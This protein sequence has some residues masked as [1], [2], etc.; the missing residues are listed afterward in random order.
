VTVVNYRLYQPADFASLYAIEEVC[1]QPPLRFG[2]RYMMQLIDTP[3]SATWIAELDGN[4]AGFAIVEFTREP[5]HETAYIPTIEVSPE[6]RGRGVGTELLRRIEG[7]AMAAGSTLIWLHVDA[8]NEAAIRLYRAQGFELKG[9]HEHYY[10]RSRAAEV[11]AKP[12][13]VLDNAYKVEGGQAS[14]QM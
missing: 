2:R 9:R 6:H 12:L 11:Y 14:Q 4:M 7:S 8:E 3:T 10:A 1:F 13:G 5:D